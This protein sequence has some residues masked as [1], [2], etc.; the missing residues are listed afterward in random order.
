MMYQNQNSLT[1]GSA[2]FG[3]DYGLTNKKGKVDETQA[4]EIIKKAISLN[5]EYID[6]A[7]VYGDSEK[8]IGKALSG[9]LDNNIKIITKLTPFDESG[10]HQKNEIYWKP[11]VENSILKSLKNL[12]VEKIDTI[13]LH[14]GSHLKNPFIIDELLRLKNEKFFENIGVSIQNTEELELALKTDYLS[15]IQIPINILDYRWER[16]VKKIEKIKQNRNLKIHARSVFLQGLLIDN[17]EKN[18][19]KA[20]V[21]DYLSIQDWILKKKKDFN[22]KSTKNL[23]ISYVNGLNWIDSLVIGVQNL[24]QLNENFLYYKDQPLNQMQIN[25]LKKDRPILDI[26]ILDPSKW[27]KN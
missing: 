1:L 12:N 23:C 18:W 26:N 6:T 4:I 16:F 19:L 21:K 24:E 10:K 15:I 7:S 8:I 17:S 25:I 20:N 14:R 3:M 27:K 5:F 11:L 2:Q 22:C 9:T 13:M